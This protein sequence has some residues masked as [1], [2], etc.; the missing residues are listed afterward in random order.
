MITKMSEIVIF[1]ASLLK[2]VAAITLAS[3][4]SNSG[5]FLNSLYLPRIRVEM[6]VAKIEASAIW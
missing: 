5:S 3:S 4:L 6:I 1:F 2:I